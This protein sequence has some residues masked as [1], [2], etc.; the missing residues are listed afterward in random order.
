MFKDMDKKMQVQ[1]GQ[2]GEGKIY[3]VNKIFI[4]SRVEYPAALRRGSSLYEL[5][6]QGFFVECEKLLPVLYKAITIS[7]GYR[8]DMVVE[9][10]HKS[11]FFPSSPSEDLACAREFVVFILH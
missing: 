11:P 8:I 4:R 1:K 3:I 9:H 5:K 6:Q 7:C 2:N 10:N